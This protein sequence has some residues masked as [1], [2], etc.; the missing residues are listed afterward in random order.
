MSIILYPSLKHTVRIPFDVFGFT[1]CLKLRDTII[2]HFATT[3]AAIYWQSSRLC[4][5]NTFQMLLKD[6]AERFRAILDFPHCHIGYKN[7]IFTAFNSLE[8]F[9]TIGLFDR[10]LFLFK[11]TDYACI[12]VNFTLIHSALSS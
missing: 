10:F 5:V 4:L 12:K 7:V 9:N 2:S 6:A 8:Q 1:I 11:V 3:A